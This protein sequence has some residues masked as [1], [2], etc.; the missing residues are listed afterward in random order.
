LTFSKTKSKQLAIFMISF[1]L[2]FLSIKRSLPKFFEVC[3]RIWKETWS[4]VVLQLCTPSLALLSR[5]TGAGLY[6]PL[7]RAVQHNGKALAAQRAA[8]SAQVKRV[9]NKKDL[10]NSSF[11]GYWN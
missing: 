10:K 1:V 6:P 8:K 4:I 7:C 5:W 3:L 11:F 2:Y 9:G